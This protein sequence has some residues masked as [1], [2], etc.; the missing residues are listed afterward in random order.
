MTDSEIIG[1]IEARRNEPPDTDHSEECRAWKHLGL[2]S[3][4]TVADLEAMDADWKNKAAKD[5]L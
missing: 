4:P 5:D 1:R 2:C 3:C